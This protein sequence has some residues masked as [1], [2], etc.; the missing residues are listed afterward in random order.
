VGQ[1]RIR[2]NTPLYHFFHDFLAIR[3][4]EKVWVEGTLTIRPEGEGI[5]VCRKKGDSLLELRLGYPGPVPWV[6]LL[7]V[8]KFFLRTKKNLFR[9]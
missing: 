1:S 3:S 8:Q 4:K 5:L 9:D 2:K 6:A 7:H